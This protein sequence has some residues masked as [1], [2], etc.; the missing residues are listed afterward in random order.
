M[1]PEIF[2][3][4]TTF[5]NYYIHQV[6]L[7]RHLLGEP[8]HVTHADPSAVLL[9]GESDS[10]IPCVIEMA[11]YRTTADWQEC[12]LVAFDRGYVELRLPAPL[13][14]NRP[15]SVR[16]FKDPGG[17]TKPQTVVPQF[18]WVGS[19]RKQAMNFLAA[20][21][22]DIKP[23]CDAREAGEDLKVAREYIGLL[24]SV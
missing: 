9:V 20:V 11:P 23:P 13:A 5:V 19:M 1:P 2:K 4:Y 12:A 10:G 3:E 6:N 18:P 15:G 22:G 7:A 16:I 17:D 24:R 14:A 8:Y 21:R